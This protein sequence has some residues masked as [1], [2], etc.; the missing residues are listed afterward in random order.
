MLLRSP[1]HWV[2]SHDLM[3]IT[4]TGRKSGRE[5]TTPVRYLRHEE[6]IWCFTSSA[7]R[8][9]RNLHGGADVSL[10]VRGKDIPSRANAIVDNPGAIRGALAEFLSHFPSDAAYYGIRLDANKTPLPGD[11]ERAATETVM[12]EVN[13]A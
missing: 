7:N 4:F 12:V 1:L 2:W 5:F 13:P 8:W 6:T 9:W 3:L 10:R 11:L